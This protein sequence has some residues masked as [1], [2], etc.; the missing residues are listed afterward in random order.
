MLVVVLLLVLLVLLLVLVSSARFGGVATLV[1]VL[2][3]HECPL[4]SD[5]YPSV[6][7]CC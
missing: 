7:S 2:I 3:V 5:Y 6:L 1:A 4:L